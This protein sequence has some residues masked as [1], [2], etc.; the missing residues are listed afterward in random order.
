MRFGHAT[1]KGLVMAK[2]RRD[3][4]LDRDLADL[5]ERELLEDAGLEGSS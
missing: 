5:P 4:E 1:S 2:D 3:P